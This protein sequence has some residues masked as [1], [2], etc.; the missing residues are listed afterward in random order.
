MS[1]GTPPNGAENLL[2]TP[3]DARPAFAIRAIIAFALFPGLVVYQVIA[4]AQCAA[5]FLLVVIAGATVSWLAVR[6]NLS[7]GIPTS[8]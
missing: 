5:V 8:S 7:H 2:R 1:F 4:S 3:A 6:I